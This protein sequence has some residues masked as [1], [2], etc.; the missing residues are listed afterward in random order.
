M[1]TSGSRMD[2]LAEE[3]MALGGWWGG[4]H[5][6]LCRGLPPRPPSPRLFHRDPPRF[7]GL[8]PTVW[9][10]TGGGHARSRWRR[11]VF[12]LLCSGVLTLTQFHTRGQAQLKCQLRDLWGQSEGGTEGGRETADRQ[13]RQPTLFLFRIQTRYQPFGHVQWSPTDPRQVCTSVM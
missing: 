5:G 12:S 3:G 1:A 2:W 13:H 11:G 6:A 7:V 4:W 9:S 8:S 10:G